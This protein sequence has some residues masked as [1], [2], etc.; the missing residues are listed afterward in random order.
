MSVTDTLELKTGPAEIAVT[1]YSPQTAKLLEPGVIE[2]GMPGG[3]SLSLRYDASAVEARLAVRELSDTRLRKAWGP[4]LH[5][6]DLQ[7]SGSDGHA[8]L[9][10]RFVIAGAES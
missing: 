9:K 8:S 6:I 10:M 4:R 7:S 1:M 2:L 3:R 5:R